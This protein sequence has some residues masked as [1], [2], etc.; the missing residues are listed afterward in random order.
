MLQSLHKFTELLMK[1]SWV[2][3]VIGRIVT[4]LFGSWFRNKERDYKKV[5]TA[6]NV[7][8]GK[9]QKPC[10]TKTVQKN[11]EAFVLFLKIAKNAC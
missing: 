7:F 1:V 8:V 11:Q 10:G 2:K 6:T 4:L 3:E 5:Q 9:R